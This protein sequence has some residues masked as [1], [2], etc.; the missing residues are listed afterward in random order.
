MLMETWAGAAIAGLINARARADKTGIWRYLRW[1]INPFLALRLELIVFQPPVARCPTGGCFYYM[2]IAAPGYARSSCMRRLAE[3]GTSTRPS[4]IWVLVHIGSVLGLIPTLVHLNHGTV[5]ADSGKDALAPRIGKNLRAQFQVCSCCS[6]PADRACR[7][8]SIRSK[9]ELVAKQAMQSVIIHKQH[10]EI[11]GRAANLVS[12]ASSLDGEEHRSAPSVRRAA[13]DDSATVATAKDEGELLISR[14]NG[15][16]FRRIQQ[17]VRDALIGRIHNLLEDL[18]RL[19]YAI[20]IV[21]EVRIRTIGA[22]TKRMV[23][24]I[25]RCLTID[26]SS[27]TVESTLNPF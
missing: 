15:N 17:I 14:D 10:N 23:E 4:N 2:P 18:G 1:Y 22:A 6:A 19:L 24:K 12:H 11:G 3:D 25:R 27:F 16:A 13:G 26:F 8:R 5:Q 21:L 20:T 7:N 9:F